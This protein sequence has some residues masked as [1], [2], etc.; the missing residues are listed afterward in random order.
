MKGSHF[1]WLINICVLYWIANRWHTT[2]LWVLEIWIV[3]CYILQKKKTFSKNLQMLSLL[4]SCLDIIKHLTF[5]RTLT[6][7]GHLW[8]SIYFLPEAQRTRSVQDFERWRNPLFCRPAPD[9]SHATGLKVVFFVLSQWSSLEQ[10]RV[11]NIVLLSNIQYTYCALRPIRL[12]I[13]QL[14][15]GTILWV[16]LFP[17]ITNRKSLAL[18]SNCEK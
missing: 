6:F 17:S 15:L 13:I 10:R 1:T 5:V 14:V 11:N 3:C 4:T 7:S 12:H 18:K 2:H 16:T 9:I 8:T